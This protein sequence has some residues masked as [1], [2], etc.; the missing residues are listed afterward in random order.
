MERTMMATN[1]WARLG[2][3]VSFA[4]E[5]GAD[6]PLSCA[7]EDCGDLASE[8][9]LSVDNTSFSRALAPW[10]TAIPFPA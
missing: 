5:V 8:L 1:G 6:H 10:R 4:H 2:T 9:A 7:A 3:R